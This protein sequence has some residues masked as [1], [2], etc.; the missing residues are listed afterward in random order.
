MALQARAGRNLTDAE[1]AWLE[2]FVSVPLVAWCGMY[3][4]RR[5]PLATPCWWPAWG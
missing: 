5:S 3:T 2:A 1:L 4:V